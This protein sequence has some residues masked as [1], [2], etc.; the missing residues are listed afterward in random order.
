MIDSLKTSQAPLI[1]TD[2]SER[3]R[4]IVSTLGT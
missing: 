2:L 3:E 4:E 1:G